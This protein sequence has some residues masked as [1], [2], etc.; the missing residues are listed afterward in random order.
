[1]LLLSMII[2]SKRSNIDEKFI[3]FD[4]MGKD[5]TS[6]WRIDNHITKLASIKHSTEISLIKCRIIKRISDI[7]W[8][9]EIRLNIFNQRLLHHPSTFHFINIMNQII[10]DKVNLTFCFCSIQP[11]RTRI[12]CK[13]HLWFGFE[14]KRWLWH[15]IGGNHIICGWNDQQLN[16]RQ[17]LLNFHF[18]CID[19]VLDLLLVG[20]VK[21]EVLDAIVVLTE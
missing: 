3:S 2:N 6:L 21:S 7:K 12:G 8:L 10:I 17:Y 1:M 19:N 5:W 9:F 20:F 16:I 15:W 13:P 14:V 11:Y 4:F 18:Q